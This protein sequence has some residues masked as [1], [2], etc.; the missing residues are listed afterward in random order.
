MFLKP[1]HLSDL[2]FTES[3]F[4]FL[5]LQL[6]AESSESLLGFFDFLLPLPDLNPV[7]LLLL[8]DLLLEIFPFLLQPVQFLLGG[9][10]LVGQVV[11]DAPLLLELV[12]GLHEFSVLF[13]HFN[14]LLALPLAV[15]FVFVLL[16]LK[17]TH[18]L[19]PHSQFV[20]QVVHLPLVLVVVAELL[21][22]PALVLM[23]FLQLFHLLREPLLLLLRLLQ[24][25]L[26]H[27]QFVDP[28]ELFN[29]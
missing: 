1:L 26:E 14:D 18:L 25:L 11:D 20:H 17:F 8:T 29:F 2:E 12:D 13:L 7:L 21:Q 4:L 22:G 24:F 6:S 16:L 10:V 27:H 28:T 3:I 9:F 23:L 15:V 5:G 19:L